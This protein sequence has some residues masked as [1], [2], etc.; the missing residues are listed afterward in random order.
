MDLHFARIL[1]PLKHLSDKD[2]IKKYSNKVSSEEEPEA[3]IALLEIAAKTAI[4]LGYEIDDREIRIDENKR[5]WNDYVSLQPSF[6][7]SH[8]FY[9]EKLEKRDYLPIYFGSEFNQLGGDLW[10][11]IDRKTGEIITYL[12]GQ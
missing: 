4:K 7:D 2:Q 8:P 12:R 9:K 6:W 10:V 1:I 11:F 5:L 3:K